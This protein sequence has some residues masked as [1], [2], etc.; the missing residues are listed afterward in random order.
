MTGH[1]SNNFNS[2]SQETTLD[3]LSRTIEDL[4]EKIL[5]RSKSG[6]A[7]FTMQAPI[8]AQAHNH[9]QAQAYPSSDH[10]MGEQIRAR[11]QSLSGR[12][13]RAHSAASSPAPAPASSN[14][15]LA[16]AGQRPAPHFQLNRTGGQPAQRAAQSA[17][18][19]Q[20]ASQAGSSGQS[21]LASHEISAILG[22]LRQELKQDMQSTF[23]NELGHIQSEMSALRSSATDPSV[24]ASIGADLEQI[25]F[26]LKQLETQTPPEATFIAG[27]ELDSLR[28][29]V[30]S[31]RTLVDTVAKQETLIGLENRWGAIEDTLSGFDPNVMHGELANLAM[32]LEDI[33]HVM[34]TM[35]QSH[36][37]LGPLEDKVEMITN[38]LAELIN[39]PQQMDQSS[40][41]VELTNQ[42]DARLSQLAQQMEALSQRSDQ[43][44]IDHGLGER[45]ESISS[46]LND[47]AEDRGL[48]GLE[49]R[50]SNLQLSLQSNL[51]TNQTLTHSPQ[52]DERLVELV[53]KVDALDS[54]AASVESTGIDKLMMQLSEV[55]QRFEEKQA[56]TDIPGIDRLE[57]QLAAIANRLDQAPAAT[58]DVNYQ[59]LDIPIAQLTKIAQRFEDKPQAPVELPGLERLEHQLTAIAERLDHTNDGPS[60][61]FNT[62]SLQ[63]QIAQLS[64]RISGTNVDDVSETL[65]NLQEHLNTN[66]EYVLEAARQAAEATLEAYNNSSH[67]SS[68]AAPAQDNQMMAALTSDLKDLESLY[69]S[70]D[71]RSSQA[72]E[73]VQQTLIKI[74]DR[75]EHMSVAAPTAQAQM[76][77][78]EQLSVHDHQPSVNPPSRDLQN[79]VEAAASQFR[80]PV[81]H[82]QDYHDDLIQDNSARGASSLLAGLTGKIKRDKSAP[83]EQEAPIQA[84]V[85][86]HVSALDELESE[87]A[88]EPLE[89]GSGAPDINSIM[90]KVRDV[91]RARATQPNP[92]VDGSARQAEPNDYIASARRAA[93][94][95]AAEV[96]SVP[97][98]DQ[99]PKKWKRNR[100]QSLERPEGEKG[101][102]LIRKPVLIAAGA[103]LLA[104]MAIPLAMN[105]IGSDDVAPEPQVTEAVPQTDNLDGTGLNGFNDG[106]TG[107]GID[108]GIGNSAL[109]NELSMSKDMNETGTISE[110]GPRVINTKTDDLLAGQLDVPNPLMAPDQLD[111]PL[112]DEGNLTT[113]VVNEFDVS[114]YAEAA[115]LGDAIAPIALK[116]AALTGDPVALYEIGSRYTEG[117]RTPVMLDKATKWLKLSADQNFAPAQYRLGNFYEKG[118]GVNRDIE[119]AK[120]L[121]EAAAGNGNINAM[122]NLGVLYASNGTVG[123]FSKAAEWFLAAAEHGVRD[124]QVNMAILYARGEGIPRDLVESYK[125]F[126][127]AANEGD[128]D[129]AL[130][131]D[132]VFNALPEDQGVL[133]RQKAESWKVTTPDLIANNVQIPDSW[134]GKGTNTASIDMKKAIKN[135]QGIL[136]NNGFDAGKPDGVIGA[137]TKTAIK[138]FQNSI[139]MKADG[140]ITDK[141]VQELLKR[142]G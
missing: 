11:Q 90:Q 127:I 92:E 80:Q 66:D 81:D 134:I 112:I 58:N 38:A 62:D 78:T 86:H 113:D 51:A 109:P 3:T 77:S 57:H 35:P 119:K 137:K 117:R 72:F 131:R 74:A 110:F 120:G 31:L 16:Q 25:A 26:S 71:N 67:A 136:N 84:P 103:I 1:R 95:A 128:T 22:Q 36:A 88:D 40:Q 32:R 73:A 111:Q 24:P 79:Q 82:S 56:S 116:Q 89:P 105:F 44:M 50:I 123:D 47:L 13:N 48:S 141:L 28:L 96:G 7:H 2:D 4:E 94:A 142:N 99:K 108:G 133:A 46:R 70:S 41:F 97:A 118:T 121:Y 29:E 61:Q 93:M 124:S 33:R 49:E 104:M 27:G 106:G 126:A 138:G 98:D 114:L 23:H 75:L 53:N 34:S 59:G 14:P 10:S 139:G 100:G 125:W 83:V 6:P 135:I 19:P 68:V 140:E 55:A 115:E 129:A 76:P 91:Q 30:D 69:R 101:K 87:F 37:A 9:V 18:I 15:P 45:I 130:K 102:S 107:G 43:G 85:S 42:T 64:E 122:H 63:E 39:R 65:A 17:P 12:D 8:Q 132:E 20:M 21:G 5:G 52:L 54:R 60:A